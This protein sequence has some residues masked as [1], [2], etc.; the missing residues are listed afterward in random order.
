MPGTVH[1][2]YYL[3]RGIE[4]ARDNDALRKL[5]GDLHTISLGTGRRG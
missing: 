1:T 2:W 5:I 3:C 4:D